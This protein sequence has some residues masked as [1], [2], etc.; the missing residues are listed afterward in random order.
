MSRFIILSLLMLVGCGAS[1][2][3]DEADKDEVVI[4]SP[5]LQSSG[6][7]HSELL[8]VIRT[9]NGAFDVYEEM[10][11]DCFDGSVTDFQEAHTARGEKLREK[12][13]V[14][15]A[16]GEVQPLLNLLEEHYRHVVASVYVLGFM[17]ACN[18]R[19]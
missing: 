4:S 11:L 16:S 7:T 8:G 18:D 10:S 3:P 14:A 5:H 19:E 2:I 15:V 12:I 1:P 9:I 6:M 17:D 13:E